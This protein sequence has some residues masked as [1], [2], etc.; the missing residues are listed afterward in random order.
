MIARP[1]RWLAVIDAIM[2]HD[3]AI[4]AAVLALTAVARVLS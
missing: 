4:G 2:R 1:N 3:W